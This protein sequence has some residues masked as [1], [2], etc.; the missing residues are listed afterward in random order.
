[1]L[2][3]AVAAG[4]WVSDVR[5]PTVSLPSTGP[6]LTLTSGDSLSRDEDSTDTDTID[7]FTLSGGTIVRRGSPLYRS[8]RQ[9]PIVLDAGP[10]SGPAQ[11]ADWTIMMYSSGS[12]EEFVEQV[13]FRDLDQISRV[14]RGSNIHVVTEVDG[15]SRLAEY[16]PGGGG[17]LP[18]LNTAGGAW[19]GEVLHA[20][21]QKEGQPDTRDP[22]IYLRALPGQDATTIRRGEIDMGDGD[23]LRT[24]VEWSKE[25]YPAER[26]ALVVSGHGLGWKGTALDR[27]A[28]G[29][30]S[31]LQVGE[32][33]NA[34]A[35]TELDLLLFN[36]CFMGQQE[37]AWEVR[38]AA[39]VM[40]GC[41]TVCWGGQYPFR[42]VIQELVDNPDSSAEELATELVGW[43]SSWLISEP[44]ANTIGGVW[45]VAAFALDERMDTL[46]GALQT[47]ALALGA[48][49]VTRDP[50]EVGGIDDHGGGYGVTGIRWDNLQLQVGASLVRS[51]HLGI[52]DRV[53]A[54]FVDLRHFSLLLRDN[55]GLSTAIREAAGVVV[56]AVDSVVLAKG[57]GSRLN[58]NSG[59]IGISFPSAQ[60]AST[61]RVRKVAAL[62]ET[63]FDV[64]SS[65]TGGF[66]RTAD[67]TSQVKYAGDLDPFRCGDE[68]PE[69]PIDNAPQFDFPLHTGWGDM[70]HRFYEPVADADCQLATIFSGGSTHCT[71]AGSTDWDGTVTAFTWD[72]DDAIDT[73]NDD[74][75]KDCRQEANDDSD[76]GGSAVDLSY[77]TGTEPT[78][79]GV[80]LTVHDD[81]HTR[82]AG[83]FE[84]DQDRTEVT[85]LPFTHYVPTLTTEG[86]DE[87]GS[88]GALNI[89]PWVVRVEAGSNALD[90]LGVTQQYNQNELFLYGAFDLS[91]MGLN[92]G[93]LPAGLLGCEIGDAGL[94]LWLWDWIN[95]IE[96]TP[97]QLDRWLD[98]VEFP[99][100]QP[101][102]AIA[103]AGP[104]PTLAAGEEGLYVFLFEPL[105]D[106]DGD[107]LIG[108]IATA[109]A[110]T[111]G[112]GVSEAPTAYPLP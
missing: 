70:L 4:I 71:G 42:Q 88:W 62:Q 50:D 74:V 47:L 90:G 93:G 51:Q 106:A 29:G 52:D 1:M 43:T 27:L 24:F 98:P 111:V 75:D 25:H 73:D 13:A 66:A 110:D 104:L 36:S 44:Q 26:Y 89:I 80:T 94:P 15:H 81:H 8:L 31:V 2:D 100:P 22:I 95:G 87:I 23:N 64:P 79:Y 99:A 59:G 58:Q 102:D 46:G 14:V 56:D 108:N 60:T 91:G 83:H 92:P 41:E 9:H 72:R 76:A 16:T 101:D 54:D 61:P 48:D 34:L 85:V 7:D 20:P 63:P 17:L 112:E 39:D 11:T 105:G 35:N 28:S 55:S 5:V 10:Q 21:P 78:T 49:S 40:V 6:G 32:L 109:A 45:T 30:Q 103:Q 65:A 84:T 37:V 77:T 53:G 69:H 57:L 3:D 33:G 12:S 82:H 86:G 107:G 68:K 19:R 67:G 97:D 18:V 38:N 96:W